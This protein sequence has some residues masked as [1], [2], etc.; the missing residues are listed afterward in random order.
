MRPLIEQDGARADAPGHRSWLTREMIAE[1]PRIPPALLRSLPPLLV[2]ASAAGYLWLDALEGSE[3]ATPG[4][5][6]AAHAG[7]VLLQAL[8]LLARHR[9]PAPALAAI[10]AVDAVLLATSG[11]ELGIGS[12]AVMFAAYAATAAPSP[13]RRRALAL[14]AAAAATAVVGGA[15]L[16]AA[17]T[18]PAL[19]ALGVAA[20]RVLLDYAVPAAIAE[21]VR[22]RRQLVEALRERAELAEREQQGRIE[23]ERL[24][25]RTVMARE[26]H[27]IAAHHLSGIIVSAQAV[28]ALVDRDPARAGAM[29]AALQQDARTTMADLRSTVGLLRADGDGDADGGEGGDPTPA[30]TLARIPELADSAVRRGRHVELEVTGEPIGLGPLAE[31]AGYRMVQESLANAARHAPGA[32]CRIRVEHREDEIAISVSNDPAPGGAAA[33][34]QRA[35]SRGYGLEGMEERAELIGA[36]L[37]TGPTADGGWANRLRIPL[38]RN[39]S[40]G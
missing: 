17:G 16:L 32:A 25:E 11:G 34:R 19:A 26:L 18:A 39:R 13:P 31:T 6:A 37:D 38:D 4:L 27:D 5:P 3:H 35:A 1:P 21:A 36:R 30:P 33:R 28:A 24:A 7:L 10:A 40:I 22:G 29:L 9:A 2:A 12:L 20:V 14:G 8:V 23:R 15:S